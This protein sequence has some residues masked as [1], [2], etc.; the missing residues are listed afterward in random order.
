MSELEILAEVA[1]SGLDW[2]NGS[3]YAVAMCFAG[4]QCIRGIYVQD[5]SS[6]KEK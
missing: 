1:E 5:K 2:V 6:E 4:Y 3:V